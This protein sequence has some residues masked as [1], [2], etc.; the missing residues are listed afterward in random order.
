MAGLGHALRG[1]R[2][3][4]TQLGLL[5]IVIVVAGLPAARRRYG[6]RSSVSAVPEYWRPNCS[7]RPS[8]TCRTTFTRTC[9]RAF[10]SSK[11]CAAAAVLCAA[12]G[13]LGVDDRLRGGARRALALELAIV[14]DL[15]KVLAQ[16]HAIR[17]QV[18]RGTEFRG[19]G[20]ETVAATGLLAGAAAL[21]QS[22]QLKHPEDKHH[23]VSGD[24]DH[25][26]CRC[27]TGHEPADHQPHPARSLGLRPAD[28]LLRGGVVSA[29]HRGG[30]AGDGGADSRRAASHV[31][32]A[33][34]MADFL[35]ARHFLRP[36]AFLPR[37]MFA[38][39]I[40]FL[41][42]GALCLSTGTGERALSPWQMGFPF[43]VGQLLLAAVLKF[44][45]R[46]TDEDA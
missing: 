27:G 44:G 18:A 30:H 38:V 22:I 20:A 6:G 5:L 43:G 4:R 24:L 35:R 41:A 13:A 31:D 33:R 28:D 10:A 39:G 17:G 34:A 19:Y 12:L 9:I 16:I 8:S 36:A 42:T 21:V 14:A 32:A 11:D 29:G 37:Q 2:S 23:G 25:D 46:E 15:S 45:F 26:G 7:T 1:E 40:W 3:L